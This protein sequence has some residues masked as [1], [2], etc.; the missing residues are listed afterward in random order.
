MRPVN[1]LAGAGWGAKLKC[2]CALL[3]V[4]AVL[5]CVLCTSPDGTGPLIES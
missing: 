3:L 5:C 4:P 2:L 1:L